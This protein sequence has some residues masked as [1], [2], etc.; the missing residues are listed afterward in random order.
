MEQRS[1]EVT[2]KL[3][4]PKSMLFSSAARLT[5]VCCLPLVAL[6]QDQLIIRKF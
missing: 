5:P 2:G 6:E 3:L 1:T 4:A